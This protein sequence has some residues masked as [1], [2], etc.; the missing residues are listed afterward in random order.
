MM[1]SNTAAPLTG[2][3]TTEFTL[4]EVRLSAKN[5]GKP[6][7]IVV[8]TLIRNFGGADENSNQDMGL[9]VR[10]MDRLKY[11]L[12]SCVLTVHHSGQARAVRKGLEVPVRWKGR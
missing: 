9:F 10:H 3:E 4:K 8:D 1:V 5:H 2:K 6:V 11:E 7:L 12:E